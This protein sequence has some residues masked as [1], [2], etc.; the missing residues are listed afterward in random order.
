MLPNRWTR[1]FA[2]M[3]ERKKEL[4][5]RSEPCGDCP[6][7]DLYFEFVEGL[8]TQPAKTIEDYSKTWFCHT[9]PHLACR[10]NWDRQCK[11]LKELNS[12]V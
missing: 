4:P 3:I 2:R 5:F 10:G 8:A 11:V 9:D 7:D 6:V 12:E 1:Y